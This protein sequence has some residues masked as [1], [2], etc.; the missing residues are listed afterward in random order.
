MRFLTFCAV[1]AVAPILAAQSMVLDINPSGS[2]VSPSYEALTL[3]STVY[4]TADDGTNGLEVWKT[5]GTAGGTSMLKDIVTGSGSSYPRYLTAWGSNLIFAAGS[6]PWISDS[7]TANTIQLSATANQPYLFT[8]FNGEMYFRAG[9]ATA[10]FNAT[11]AATASLRPRLP[12]SPA[13]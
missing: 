3:G 6:R 13:H 12:A 9:T 8:E 7:T 1:L 4:F 10:L 11:A 2:S 5:D